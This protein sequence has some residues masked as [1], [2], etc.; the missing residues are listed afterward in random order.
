MVDQI[1]KKWLLKF[2]GDPAQYKKHTRAFDNLAALTEHL[3]KQQVSYNYL[4][5]LLPL[6]YCPSSTLTV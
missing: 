2:G 3:I 1:V 4:P 6:D 5:L